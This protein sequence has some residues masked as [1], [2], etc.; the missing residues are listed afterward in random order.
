MLKGSSFT[1]EEIF[2][3]TGRTSLPAEIIEELLDEIKNLNYQLR[4]KQDF[5]GDYD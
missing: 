2:K 4:L 3:S 1:P 5:K